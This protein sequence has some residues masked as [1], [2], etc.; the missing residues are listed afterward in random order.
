VIGLPRRLVAF[1]RHLGELGLEIRMLRAA[2]AVDVLAIAGL[3]MK[4]SMT[5]W[6]GTLS[7]ISIL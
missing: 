4:P 7:R 5:R 6:N 3:A 1:E 2:G